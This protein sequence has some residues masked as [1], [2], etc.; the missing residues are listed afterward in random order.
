MQ[1]KEKVVKLI[2]ETKLKR[3]K[4]FPEKAF[5]KIKALLETEM[6]RDTFLNYF[7]LAETATTSNKLR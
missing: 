7:N 1:Q 4:Q 3:N 2:Y 6:T 5:L